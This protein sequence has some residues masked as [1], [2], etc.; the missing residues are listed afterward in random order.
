MRAI[1]A[2]EHA[3]VIAAWNLHINGDIYRDPGAD[4]YTGRQPARATTRA[5]SQL[6]TLGYRVTLEPL[7][8]AG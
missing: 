7:N 6:E 2:V 8:Q 5:V 4:Y 3:M 1:V